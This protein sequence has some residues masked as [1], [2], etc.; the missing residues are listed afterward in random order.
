MQFAIQWR[1]EHWK[2][3]LNPGD[4]L[5]TNHPGQSFLLDLGLSTDLPQKR[6][7]RTFLISQWLLLPSMP[8]LKKLSSMSLRVATIQTLA[9]LELLAVSLIKILEKPFTND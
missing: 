6:E 1:H 3:K 2:G 4:A 9:G 5:L 8:S 7:A